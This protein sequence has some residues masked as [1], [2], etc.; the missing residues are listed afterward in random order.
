MHGVLGIETHAAVWTSLQRGGSGTKCRYANNGVS[1]THHMKTYHAPNGG[2]MPARLTAQ[3]STATPMS[4]LSNSVFAVGSPL[5]RTFRQTA[6]EGRHFSRLLVAIGTHAKRQSFN[7][8]RGSQCAAIKTNAHKNVM[9]AELHTTTQGASPFVTSV[10]PGDVVGK[11]A[12]A[13]HDNS[14]LRFSV[15][16][17]CPETKRNQGVLGQWNIT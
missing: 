3:H 1:R 15:N 4:K 8:L 11:V 6:C 2:R 13:D 17:T 12:V 10:I 14:G 7:A 5:Q 9:F 16:G